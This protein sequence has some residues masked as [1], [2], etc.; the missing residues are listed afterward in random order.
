MPSPPTR[1]LYL[2]NSATSSPKP[3]A[4]WEAM[5]RYVSEIGASPGRGRYAEAREGARLIY[6]CR[7]R[8][9]RLIN[10]ESPDH[11]VFTLNTTD[12][13]NLA[14]KG[15]V[16]HR[17]R[18]S[19]GG[20]RAGRRIHL[21]TT[22]LDH[23]SVLRPF[24]ALADEGAEWTCVACDPATGIVDPNDVRRAL[25]PDTALVAVVHASNV[26]GA[27]Q[28]VG[29]IGRICRER[30]VPFLVDAAQSLGHVPID[31][32]ALAID[33]LAF[34]GHKGLLGPLGTGGLYLRP[35]M[36]R[37]VRTVRE[38][39][40]GTVSELDVHPDSMP[41]KYE[42]GSHNTIGIIGLSEGVNYLLDRGV[43]AVQRHERELMRAMLECLAE[44][45]ATAGREGGTGTG[46]PLRL[47][48]PSAV[49][50]RVGVFSLVHDDLTPHQFADLLEE[51]F[52]IL[53]RSGIHCAPRAHAGAA[54]PGG[55]TTR[56]SLGPFLT[57]DDIRYV[58][59]ALAEICGAGR[60]L[61]P[62]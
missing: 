27:L 42:P 34:P 29:E 32:R 57:T 40:T 43:E 38:G 15:V 56:L 47:I 12:A 31:V 11:V 54:A 60:L 9:N 52:G 10:G 19:S 2:D 37:L 25:R 53:A 14:I 5:A 16:G 6:Q 41:E 1:R 35:G 17:R 58:G 30:A 20:G 33:L 46:G 50:G 26:T 39:G 51:R 61:A 7:E 62:A 55:G 45:G 3:A 4:V 48:G 13:L 28:P 49:E 59:A 18:V 23:N 22:Q 8:I 21:V 24:N 36:E 44:L